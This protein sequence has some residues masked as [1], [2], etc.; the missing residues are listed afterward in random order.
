MLKTFQLV[1]CYLVI[2]AELNGEVLTVSHTFTT[3]HHSVN[4]N[5]G[6][7]CQVCHLKE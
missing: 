7:W 5:L 2:E 1:M 3:G 4:Y 6:K